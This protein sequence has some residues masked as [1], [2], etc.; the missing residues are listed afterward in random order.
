MKYLHTKVRVTGLD[1][2][3]CFHCDAPGVEVTRQ[4]D[5]PAGPVT[6]V[7]LAMPNVGTW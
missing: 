6:L 1:A 5:G 4:H 2:S 7:H 3:L